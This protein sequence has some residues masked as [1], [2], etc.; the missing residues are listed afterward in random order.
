M[1]KKVPS[2]VSNRDYGPVPK[3]IA[4]IRKSIQPTCN[5]SFHCQE[6]LDHV[7]EFFRLDWLGDERVEASS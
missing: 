2:K 6:T 1:L 3:A 5:L 7:V 4:T